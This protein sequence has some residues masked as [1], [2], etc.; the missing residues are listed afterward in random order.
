LL[1]PGVVVAC[2]V[3]ASLA[4]T[5][6]WSVQLDVGVAAV[7]VFFAA[8]TWPLALFSADALVG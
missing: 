1:F 3:P 7:I 4:T 8:D 6:L 5:S 2:V